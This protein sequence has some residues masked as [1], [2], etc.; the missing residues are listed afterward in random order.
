M[1]LRVIVM[2]IRIVLI[3]SNQHIRNGLV[4]LLN[5]MSQSGALES[6]L[7]HI[8]CLATFPN[9][10]SAL[11]SLPLLQADVILTALDLPDVP[12]YAEYLRQLSSHSSPVLLLSTIENDDLLAH[13]LQC[14]AM[15]C[16]PK[17]AAPALLAQTIQNLFH[18]TTEIPA[19]TA[20]IL[21]REIQ[22]I[23]SD[24]AP[25][26]PSSKLLILSAMAQGH[27]AE[28][29]AR[30]LN[31]SPTSV[32]A[33]IFELLRLIQQIGLMASMVCIR[34]SYTPFFGEQAA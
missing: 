29:T 20:Q 21:L 30:I 17:S 34:Y 26:I 31:I 18:N 22:R 24:T 23:P 19:Q 12:D 16:L 5:G 28:E 13:A 10:A 1:V 11:A 7:P 33:T 4:L 32:R 14:G 25:R 2:N 27:S 6:K 8:S 9:A 15:G 3:E